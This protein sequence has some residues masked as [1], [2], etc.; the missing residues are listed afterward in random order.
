MR[1][2]VL[3]TVARRLSQHRRRK[4]LPH[5]RVTTSARKRRPAIESATRAPPQ[6]IDARLPNASQQA[7][8]LLRSGKIM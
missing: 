1:Q 8:F 4:H 2:I 5:N 7:L 6:S 3:S